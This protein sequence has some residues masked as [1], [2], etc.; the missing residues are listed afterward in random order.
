MDL[1]NIK[2]I[3]DNKNIII[4]GNS[5]NILKSHKGSYIDSHDIVVRINHALPLKPVFSPHIGSKVNCYCAGI[6]SA[7]RVKQILSNYNKILKFALRL[8]YHG[9]KFDSPI[10]YFGTRYDYDE[11]KE[12]FKEYKPSTGSLAI[13]FFTKYINY[14]QLNLIGFDFFKSDNSSK[15]N[16]LGSF[17]YKDHSPLL[18][19]KFIEGVVNTK[20]SI[21][22]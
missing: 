6:S 20:T 11:L 1:E 16:E 14:N 10:T 19:R 7:T 22:Y 21:I 3:C 15:K 12:S 8:N 9:E 17:L 2:R 18:E 5:S 13:N 4:V